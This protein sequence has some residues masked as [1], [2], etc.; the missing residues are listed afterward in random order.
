MEAM[1]ETAIKASELRIGNWV[2]CDIM[3]GYEKIMAPIDRVNPVE[4]NY[5]P[6]PLTPEILKSAGF[7]KTDDSMFA[8]PNN[9]FVYFGEDGAKDIAYNKKLV[10]RIKQVQ[11]NEY[12]YLFRHMDY[13]HQLQNLFFA[14][15]GEELTVK[16]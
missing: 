11:F 1:T 12:E 8:L 2:A 6:I 10:A 13:L 14:L 9:L 7:E 3:D 16:L 15:T 4:K 5:Y